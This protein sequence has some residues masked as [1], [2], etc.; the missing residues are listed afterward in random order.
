M[1][2]WLISARKLLASLALVLCFTQAQ[3]RDA[4]GKRRHCILTGHYGEGHESNAKAS[5]AMLRAADPEAEIYKIEASSLFDNITEYLSLA[6]YSNLTRYL[7]KVWDFSH[8]D[9]VRSQAKFEAAEMRGGKWMFATQRLGYVLHLIEC[10]VIY[11]P[12]YFGPEM[13]ARLKKLGM[14]PQNVPL[15]FGITDYVGGKAPAAHENPE[16]D[17][18]YQ[19]AKASD[20]TAAPDGIITD[21]LKLRGIPADRVAST[22]ILINPLVDQIRNMG[23]GELESFANSIGFSSQVRTVTIQSGGDGIGNFVELTKQAVSLLGP[24]DKIQ[25]LAIIGRN[26]GKRGGLE[27]LQKKY[28][29]DPRIKLVIKGGKP[30]DRVGPEFVLKALR[31]SAHSNGYFVGKPGGISMTEA[32]AIGVLAFF[33]PGN[34]GPE[35]DNAEHVDTN[36]LAVMLASE[37][38]LSA[39]ASHYWFNPT[40][41]R[42]LA[43]RARQHVEASYHPEILI[44]WLI[45][46]SKTH[47]VSTSNWEAA[48]RRI[49]RSTR[50][51][52]NF[53]RPKIV[54]AIN[55]DT[56]IREVELHE[57]PSVEKF[58]RPLQA[59]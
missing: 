41:A 38:E 34:L 46:Q 39:K 12:W 45:A 47:N 9:Y 54:R 20:F 48:A 31:L 24:R 29:D 19:L 4:S 55:G 33:F 11:A 5:T 32:M 23:E 51:L 7:P 15:A 8:R 14:L 59:H 17:Y 10:D 18:L 56:G 58:A 42:A 13:I 30:I 40:A 37:S 27:A 44:N 57:L 6:G 16:Q 35:V 52:M 43:L 53:I 50:C 36:K 26:A 2:Y 21:T 3:A 49:P 22:G 28:A 1:H 25:I